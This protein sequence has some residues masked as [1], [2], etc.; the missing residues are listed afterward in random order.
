MNSQPGRGATTTHPAGSSRSSSSAAREAQRMNSETPNKNPATPAPAAP[1]AG[2]RRRI[3]L[4][5]GIAVLLGLLAWGAIAW[6]RSLTP[7]GA[8]AAQVE[9]H[10]IPVL[11]RVGG[12]TQ[13][14]NVRENETVRQGDTLVVL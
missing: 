4:P 12:Y 8:A 2:A 5:L 13:A 14:V 11:A 3:L 9:G 6:T 1:A 10:M 7:I